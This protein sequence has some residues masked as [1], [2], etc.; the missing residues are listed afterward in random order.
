VDT[1]ADIRRTHGASVL[2]IYLSEAHA[3]DTWP[4]SSD[5]PRSHSNLESRRDAATGFLSRWPQFA[6]EVQCSFVDG[7]ND[8]NTIAKGL[9]PERYLVIRHGVVTWASVLTEEPIDELWHAA[10]RSFQ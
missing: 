6:R 1:L 9:W 7:M 10:T 3:L 4:L 5:A 8:E 2:F